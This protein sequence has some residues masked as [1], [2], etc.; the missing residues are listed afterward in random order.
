MD[1]N[2]GNDVRRSVSMFAVVHVLTCKSNLLLLGESQDVERFHC[3]WGAGA[4]DG[5][6]IMSK[7]SNQS[8]V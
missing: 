7:R 1:I 3:Q 2:V 6:T 8:Y 4:E 5:N